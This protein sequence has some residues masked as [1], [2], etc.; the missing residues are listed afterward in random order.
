MSHPGSG[1]C[2]AAPPKQRG[3]VLF[4]ALIALVLMSMIGITM[5]RQMTGGQQ[6]IGNLGFKQGATSV[7]DRATEAART[8][9]TGAASATLDANVVGNAYYASAPDVANPLIPFD[10]TV[11]DWTNASIAILD[12]GN[13]VNY[14]VQRLC[15]NVGVFE[16]QECVARETSEGYEKGSGSYG[17]TGGAPK[18]LQPYY[19][20]TSRVTGARNSVSYTQVIMY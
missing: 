14:I 7:A 1:R 6:I 20:V 13:S 5:V 16:D 3:V 2:F 10:P 15:N 18:Q 19:R 17:G 12:D 11:Y 4:I 8:F 9:V